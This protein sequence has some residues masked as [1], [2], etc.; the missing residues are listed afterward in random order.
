M[1]STTSYGSEQQRQVSYLKRPTLR[2]D[3]I[4]LTKRCC[5]GCARFRQDLAAGSRVPADVSKLQEVR[6]FTGYAEFQEFPADLSK[7]VTPQILES[8]RI[9]SISGLS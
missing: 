1:T 5:S 2:F 6:E 3:E 9:E 8:E 7:C 4:F